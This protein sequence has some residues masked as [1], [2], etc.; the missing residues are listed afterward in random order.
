MYRGSRNC[1]RRKNLIFSVSS[2]QDSENYI[3]LMNQ[4]DPQ[5][6]DKGILGE[7]DLYKRADLMLQQAQNLGCREFVTPADVVHGNPK[8]NLA[9]VA[10]LFDKHPSIEQ[11]MAAKSQARAREI[12]NA[13]R[14][15]LAREEE[16][17]R[18]K[19]KQEEDAFR[20]RMQ[21]EERALK[22]RY[23]VGEVHTHIH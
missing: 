22:E 3:V 5:H 8:L 21:D 11:D 19:W 1:F 16:E 4:L 23:C 12:E 18:Q 7:Q 15:K 9:F 20:R 17:M 13:T 2:F 10:N 14:S 6:C